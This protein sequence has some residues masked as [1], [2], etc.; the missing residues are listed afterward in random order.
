MSGWGGG[1]VTDITYM[2]GCYRQ[3]SPSVI[4][5]GCLLGGV[6]SPLPGPDD[7]LSYVELGCGQGL[8]A[9]ILAASNPTLE[10][11][12]DR[13]QPGAYRGGSRLG[14]AGRARQCQ[15]PR[16]RSVHPGRGCRGGAGARSRLRQHAWPVE[17]GAPG[18]AGR[19]RPPA[20]RQGE[21]GR[22]G[23]C[24]LQRVAGL[25]RRPRHAAGDARLRPASRL[26][27]ATGRPKRA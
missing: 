10:G 8:G 1:Y 23:A 2:T 21:A 18:R 12:R 17:L 20:A 14:S 4:A 27:A 6:A 9:L 19:H 3:Q 26:R 24:Q 13:L 16:G 11:H 22:R 25:G 7:P 5:L 15:L